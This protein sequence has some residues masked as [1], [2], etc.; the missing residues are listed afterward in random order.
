MQLLQGPEDADAQE[1]LLS[2][3]P[4][5]THLNADTS[6]ILSLPYPAGAPRPVGRSLLN[7][8]ID[9]WLQGPQ[10]DL[11]SWF[12]QQWHAVASSVQTIADLNHRLG[13]IESVLQ[14][15]SLTS[16]EQTHRASRVDSEPDCVSYIDIVVVSH[17]F[18]DH[19]NRAT[20][21]EIPANTPVLATEAAARMISSWHHFHHVHPIPVFSKLGYDWRKSPA[22]SLPP[23]LGLS[24][25]T[26][27]KRDRLNLHSAILITFDVGSRSQDD[28]TEGIIYTPHGIL[29]D[30]L[31]TLSLASPRIAVL[32]LLHGLHDIKLSRKQL[33]LG[34]H[35]ALRAHRICGAKYWLSTRELGLA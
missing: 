34:A 6:W 14:R 17:E 30:A 18:T 3:R 21:L 22:E 28:H 7:I 19:C 8:L 9:P 20:L 15:G 25:I 27:S 12:S 13:E 32:A 1:A 33:N 31:Q 5:L 26:S 23:W 24:R 11:A 16:S 29:A 10:K 4:V 2:G 35:N